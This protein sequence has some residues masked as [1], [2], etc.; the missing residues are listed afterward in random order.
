MK[1][2]SKEAWPLRG[3]EHLE[4]GDIV[5]VA[6]PFYGRGSPAGELKKTDEDGIGGSCSYRVVTHFSDHGVHVDVVSEMSADDIKDFKK[7]VKGGGS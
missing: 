5:A 6:R 2:V 1:K 7:R 4:P 3:H